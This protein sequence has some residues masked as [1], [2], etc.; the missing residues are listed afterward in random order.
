MIDPEMIK[1][2]PP[3]FSFKYNNMELRSGEDTPAEIVW[4]GDIYHIP[5][6]TNPILLGSWTERNGVW[7]LTFKD[8]RP[9]Q[10]QID[11][12]VFMGL[13]KIGQEIIEMFY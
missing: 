1:A 13:A 8:M 10:P 3:I 12:A 7:D 5:S 4:W 6:N 11:P 9:F 2:R